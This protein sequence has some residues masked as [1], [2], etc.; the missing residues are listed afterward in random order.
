[1]KIILYILCIDVILNLVISVFAIGHCVY[2]YIKR[3]IE[4]KK[5]KK[6]LQHLKEKL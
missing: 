3:K 2:D 6:Y 4:Y 5:R 1:M